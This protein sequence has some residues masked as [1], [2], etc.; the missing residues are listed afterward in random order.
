MQRR[1]KNE[2]L[3]SIRRQFLENKHRASLKAIFLRMDRDK[4]GTVDQDEFERALKSIGI[5]LDWQVLEPLF[6][7]YDSDG[8]GGISYPEFVIETLEPLYNRA[9]LKLRRF[10]KSGGQK[11]CNKSLHDGF[12]H[13]DANGNGVI[14]RD[15]FIQALKEKCGITCLKDVEIDTL[16]D[17]LDWNH[18][19]AIDYG[20]F[21]YSIFNLRP[22]LETAL[23]ISEYFKEKMRKQN[24]TIPAMNKPRPTKPIK[25][26]DNVIPPLKLA[27]V[28]LRSEK[29]QSKKQN[30]FEENKLRTVYG[31]S[32]SPGSPSD[33]YGRPILMA[34]E[35]SSRLLLPRPASVQCKYGKRPNSLLSPRSRTMGWSIYRPYHES[36]N[37]G[38]RY[39]G[40]PKT[41]LDFI[42]SVL[43]PNNV[44][45]PRPK[46]AMSRARF[47]TKKK[48]NLGID[49]WLTPRRTEE[50][51]MEEAKNTKGFGAAYPWSK[52]KPRVS[53][54][55]FKQSNLD[56][57]KGSFSPY[58][59]TDHRER[60][61]R[62]AQEDFEASLVVDSD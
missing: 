7:L 41:K 27:T 54:I 1:R 62:E 3:N 28:A 30:I 45:K 50:D 56:R 18:S 26:N 14:E 2:A 57:Y 23:G 9:L 34:E 15:E 12:E 58:L 24:E 21:A 55:K 59:L 36:F 11:F 5:V 10:L 33:E 8:S 38:S 40:E 20:E 46:T 19:G 42:A 29:K 52:P 49:P 6:Y 17:I 51:I 48:K 47:K 16:F 61:L 25:E 37:N 32:S 60:L 43:G 31:I 35:E 22:H 53:P 4:N 13:F 39:Y 44:R